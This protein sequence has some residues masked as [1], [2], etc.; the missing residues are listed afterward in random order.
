[1]VYFFTK[2]NTVGVRDKCFCSGWDDQN[3][4]NGYDNQG[5]RKS[6]YPASRCSD[7]DDADIWSNY[8]KCG[9]NHSGG[10]W[11]RKCK[12]TEALTPEKLQDMHR[13]DKEHPECHYSLSPWEQVLVGSEMQ[14]EDG[15][16]PAS[17][18]GFCEDV[19]NLNKVVSSDG[20]TCFGY[21]QGRLGDAAAKGRAV[22]YCEN[23]PEQV[24]TT[25]CSSESLGKEAY[26]RI[27]SLFCEDADLGGPSDD[28]CA[29]YNA[30]KGKCN[31]SDAREFAGCSGVNQKHNELL[32]DLPDTL[33][34]GAR[35]QLEE[36]KF[37][38]N[39]VCTSGTRF[40]PSGSDA[41]EMNLQVCINDIN[42]RGNLQDVGIN[43]V[44][45]QDMD[46][47]GSQIGGGS[48]TD[49]T[50]GGGGGD[51]ESGGDSSS[52]TILAGT[53]AVGSGVCVVAIAIAA[54]M[55]M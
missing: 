33:S 37:C 11:V 55:M 4:Y 42:V 30:Y 29:C 32:S 5:N 3:E 50:G 24:K 38:R 52:N 20:Q 26:E 13:I 44:C 21:L 15:P 48:R 18:G 14:L 46:N 17:T 45:D 34:G 10:G 40:K 53:G 49:D 41:C 7:N 43:V 35:Q 23:N 47:G 6:K 31:R 16:Y 12:V 27:A 2:A 51:G 25:A 1:M 54:A 28:F 22:T 36:R 39:N 9:Y 19:K 8:G